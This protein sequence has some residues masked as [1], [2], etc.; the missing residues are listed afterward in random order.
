MR[1]KL[2]GKELWFYGKIMTILSTER[3]SNKEILKNMVIER[4]LIFRI[5]KSQ[6]KVLGQN[7]EGELESFILTEH[8]KSKQ[9]CPVL[10]LTL[11]Q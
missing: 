9:F 7:Y 6:L 10:S 3:V 1:R 11:Y 5:R 2:E 8:I 4:S